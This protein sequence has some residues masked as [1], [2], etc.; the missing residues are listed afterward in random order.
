[1]QTPIGI[2]EDATGPVESRLP[3]F[4]QDTADFESLMEN[5]EAQAFLSQI[6]NLKGMGAL[7][8]A[9]GKKV[10]AALQS[11]NL[12]QSPKR[13]MEN[14][15]EAQRLLMKAREN[16]ANRYGVPQTIP[17]TPAVETSPEDI[18]TLLQKYGGQ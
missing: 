14:V 12:K 9:E 6:P 3:T 11:L 18:E 7:S 15:R 1:L 5:I 4:D 8:D 13:L 16:I 2:V 17:D 10:T